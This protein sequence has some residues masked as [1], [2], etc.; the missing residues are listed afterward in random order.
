[1]QRKLVSVEKARSDYG[2][3]LAPESLEL[4]V[5]ASEKLR[6]QLRQKR[7]AVSKFTFGPV[8]EP[9]GIRLKDLAPETESVSQKASSQ[10]AS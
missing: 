8:P 2:V 10:A 3:V 9:I 5:A 1:M 6:A 7:G 4:D